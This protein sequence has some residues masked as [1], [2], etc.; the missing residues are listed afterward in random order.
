MF[1]KKETYTVASASAKPAGAHTNQITMQLP[2]DGT[3]TLTQK[4]GDNPT[5]YKKF[6][7]TGH[8]G[9]DWAC[10]TG[11]PVLAAESGHVIR[12]DASFKDYGN[13]VIIWH[14]DLG[15][16]TWY[17]HLQSLTVEGGEYVEQGQ[18]IGVVG[19]TGATGGAHLH[20]ALC[21]TD[22][23]GQ[24][25]NTENGYQGFVDPAPCL[26]TNISSRSSHASDTCV[27]EGTSI[28]RTQKSGSFRSHLEASAKKFMEQHAL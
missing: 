17:G 8:E 25:I 19:N 22:D 6:G 9:L 15:C 2:F 28:N 26:E 7:L 11:T 16:A 3:Y 24:R 12:R 27:Y 4:F 20:F 13:V 21:Q 18:Q 23:N 5:Y 1:T 10:P 14:Q